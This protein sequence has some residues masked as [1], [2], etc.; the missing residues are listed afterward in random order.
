MPVG[1]LREAMNTQGKPAGGSLEELPSESP[2]VHLPTGNCALEMDLKNGTE[3][4]DREPNHKIM[5]CDMQ[6]SGDGMPD[7]PQGHC[8]CHGDVEVTEAMTY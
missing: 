5:A 3:S 8:W 7:E 4:T 2:Q 1:D 6:S